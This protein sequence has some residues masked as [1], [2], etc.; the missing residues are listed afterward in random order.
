MTPRQQK[1]SAV[2]EPPSHGEPFPHCVIRVDEIRPHPRNARTH[3]GKQIREIAASITAFGFTIPVLVDDEKVLIAGHGRLEAAKSLGMLSVPAII[4]SSLSDAKKRALL[5]ADNRIALNAGWDREQLEIEL[6][7][8]P[9]IL[10]EEGLDIS[11]SGFA[12]A[13]IDSLHADFEMT[14][15]PTDDFDDADLSRPAVSEC[16]DLWQLGK[17]RMLCGDARNGADLNRLLDGQRA[18]MAFLDP[19]TTSSSAMWLAEA[20]PSIENLQW[21]R[22][23]CP[24]TSS[25]HF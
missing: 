24:L 4:I 17:H 19:L 1:A 6:A 16:G 15:D 12:P 25:W 13:E 7:T 23:R 11:I 14:G 8:L 18:H 10:F 2:R 20:P 21:L 22:G 9:D 5:L 3:S